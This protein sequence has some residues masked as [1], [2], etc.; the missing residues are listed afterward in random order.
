MHPRLEISSQVM[1]CFQ[2]MP[3][4]RFPTL[5]YLQ[6]KTQLGFLGVPPIDEPPIGCVVCIIYIIIYI[7]IDS[8]TFCSACP[9][10]K[11]KA[12]H[13]WQLQQAPSK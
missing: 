10:K 1:V 3:V 2:C 8:S 9:T 13:P 5:G 7:I 11:T 4:G 6:E 12:E